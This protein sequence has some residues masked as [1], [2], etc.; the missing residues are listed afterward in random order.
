MTFKECQARDKLFQVT[1]YMTAGI[2]EM[3]D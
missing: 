1:D 2:L 3:F